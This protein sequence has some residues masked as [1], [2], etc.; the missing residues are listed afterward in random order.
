MIRCFQ[1][2]E[3]IAPADRGINRP[4]KIRCVDGSGKAETVFVKTRAGYGNRPSAPGVEMFTTLLAQAF[5]LKAP[6]PVVV[7][8]PVGFEQFVIGHPKHHAVVQKS[9]GINFGTV[10]LGT[11]WK[12]LPVNFPLQGFSKADLED[13]LAFDAVVQHT[14]RADANPNL[15]WRDTELAVVDHEKCFGHLS[16][17]D[18]SQRKPWADFL[19][20]R[21]LQTHC[22]RRSLGKNVPS[23]FGDRIQGEIIGFGYSNRISELIQATLEHFPEAGVDLGRIEQYFVAL[24][25]RSDDFFG[26]LRMTLER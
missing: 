22:L 26:R 4:V 2:Q 16:R 13:I 14:D 25:A 8:I 19:G 23:E 7:E 17:A 9:P 6:D 18:W 24:D 20:I 15:L 3:F 21:P 1:A 5:G 12:T 10:S 11:D